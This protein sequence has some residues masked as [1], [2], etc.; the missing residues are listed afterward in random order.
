MQLIST[1]GQH[2]SANNNSLNDEYDVVN[3]FDSEISEREDAIDP[4]GCV[5]SD[6]PITDRNDSDPYP[7]SSTNN[8][9][10]NGI[11][12]SKTV[13]IL[14]LAALNANRLHD[15][16]HNLVDKIQ[17][18]SAALPINERLIHD[19]EKHTQYPLG[20]TC[21]D[22][23]GLTIESSTPLDS[24]VSMSN[25]AFRIPS[26][27]NKCGYSIQLGGAKLELLILLSGVIFVDLFLLFVL[28]TVFSRWK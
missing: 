26:S 2:L 22:I 8:N 19:P 10:N 25:A 11:D 13:S 21:D 9:G 17:C 12:S 7:H 1:T 5:D 6:N 3:S 18:T 4:G 28:S 27:W 15:S 20:L 23:A 16:I 24:P 14:N